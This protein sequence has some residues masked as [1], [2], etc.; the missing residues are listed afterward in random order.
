MALFQQGSFIFDANTSS[1]QELARK[2]AI[3]AQLMGQRSAPRNVGEGLVA[4]GDGI[5]ANVLNRRA[6]ETEQ[7]GQASASEA[8]NPLLDAFNNRLTGGFPDAPPDTAAAPSG[9]PMTAYQ[10]AIASIESAGSGDYAAVGPSHPRLG[11]ALGRYQVMEANIGPWSEAALGRRVSPDEFMANPSLQDAIF[12]HR[13]GQYVN[14]FGPEGA[15]QAWFGGEGG[16]GK[17]DRRDSLGTSIAGYTDKFRRALGGPASPAIAANEAMAA[18]QP[19]AQTA[20]TG[21]LPLLDDVFDERFGSAP[22]NPP[23]PM[24][25]NGIPAGGNAFAQ[26]APP[27]SAPQTVQDRP[28]QVA[29][30]GG[31]FPEMAGQNP[32]AIPA[33]SG[34]DLQMLLRAASNPWLNENQRAVVNTLLEQQLQAQDPYR[35]A[36]IAQLQAQTERLQ[37]QAQG[38]DTRFGLNPI[39]GQDAEGNTVLGV[40]GDD[41]SFKPV[42]TGGVNIS[43]GVDRVDLGTHYGL[44][45]KRSGQMVGTLPKENYQEAFDTA[46]G[47]AEGKAQGEAAVNLPT[48]LATSE[49]ALSELDALIAHPGLSAIAGPFDQYRPS[50]MMGAEGRDALARFN[51]A[52]GRAFL[53]AFGMLKGGGQIT[54]IEGL[55]AEQ[56]M[57]RMDRAQGEEEFKQALQDFRDAVATGMDKMRQRAGQQPASGSDWQD[58]GGVRIRRKQ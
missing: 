23:A 1:P 46:R 29:Q 15:A 8:F 40:L 35:Q 24:D 19:V 56:A 49:Q 2:R 30:A 33:P 5:V 57:A 7:A 34:P 12:N 22:V 36:Q 37:R 58:V 54:E 6:N 20:P 3:V 11:R 43:T 17:L 39:Y 51:Q 53:Q 31:G 55:K 4:I 9:D 41:G 21:P 14:K 47:G 26:P 13:F 32:Q 18:G 16:V 52:K 44:L 45:D 50:W 28:V 27:L 42:D 10:N 25:V 48:D 38:G